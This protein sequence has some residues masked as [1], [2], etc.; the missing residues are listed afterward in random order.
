[1]LES[2]VCLL[3][4]VSFLLGICKNY[5]EKCIRFLMILS[6][7]SEL[8]LITC[9]FPGHMTKALKTVKNL[10]KNVDI[11]VEVRDARVSFA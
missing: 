6:G 5:F 11:V 2:R 4:I 3:K 7:L 10:C 9:R 8:W 1:M